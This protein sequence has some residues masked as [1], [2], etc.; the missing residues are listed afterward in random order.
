VRKLAP[1]IAL[2]ALLAACGE[3]D[4]PADAPPAEDVTGLRL[5]LDADGPGGEAAQVQRLECGGDAEAP[6]CSLVGDLPP[7]PAAPVPPDTACTDI[8]GGPDTLHVE[9]TLEGR[10][11]R[12]TFTRE[13]GCEIGRFEAWLPILKEL[14]PGYK[15]GES[16]SVP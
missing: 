9:G 13:N 4:S 3:D 12:G 16:L 15:P 6:A 8:Y 2:V 11:I 5:Q 14:F 7:D 10:P 1:A